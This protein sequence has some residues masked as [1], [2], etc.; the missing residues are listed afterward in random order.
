MF[1]LAVAVVLLALVVVFVRELLRNVRKLGDQVRATNERLAPLTD[2]L[3]SEL[4]VTSV[5]VQA[6]TASV[7]RVSKQRQQQARRSKRSLSKRKG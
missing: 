1:T 6:L 4:A 7:E 3:Q 5:E 2:E